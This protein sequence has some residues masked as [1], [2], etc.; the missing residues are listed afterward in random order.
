MKGKIFKWKM[1]NKDEFDARSDFFTMVEEMF[2]IQ[3]Y[4]ML[5]YI[6]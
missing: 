2:E 5:W 1:S 3:S 6:F 4:K